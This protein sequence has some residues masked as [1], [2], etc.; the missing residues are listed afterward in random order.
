MDLLDT[1]MKN[2]TDKSIRPYG[3]T[4]FLQYDDPWNP[5]GTMHVIGHLYVEKNRLKTWRYHITR[6]GIC[7]TH[8]FH[9]RAMK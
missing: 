1:Y 2:C 6:V 9:I 7:G 8:L 4:L 5:P 3:G